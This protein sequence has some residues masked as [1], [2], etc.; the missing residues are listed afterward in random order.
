MIYR[1]YSRLPVGPAASTE[2]VRSRGVWIFSTWD[3]I[4]RHDIVFF[5]T[6]AP[7]P[8]AN[9]D[10]ESPVLYARIFIGNAT[11]C[12]IYYYNNMIYRV[13]LLYTYT[14]VRI[15]LLLLLLLCALWRRTPILQNDRTFGRSTRRVA[16]EISSSSPPPPKHPYSRPRRGRHHRENDV[17]GPIF[18]V[19]S[20]YYPHTSA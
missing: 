19:V 13:C 7:S 16:G 8:N 17:C 11:R 20:I 14:A 6:A 2:V 4:A 18:F 12:I 5:T 10:A 1:N 3:F 15:L 9:S